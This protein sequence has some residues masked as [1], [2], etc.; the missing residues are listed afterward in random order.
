[1][2]VGADEWAAENEC[3]HAWRATFSPLSRETG[4]ACVDRCHH[5]R[6]APHQFL[7]SVFSSWSV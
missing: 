4:I 3:C 2:D 7:K 5:T 1:M 6:K